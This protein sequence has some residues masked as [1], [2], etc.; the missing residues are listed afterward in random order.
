M[1]VLSYRGH[2]AI[3][4]AAFVAEMEAHAAADRI[5]AGHYWDGYTGCAIGCGLSSI[6]GLQGGRALDPFDP[7]YSRHH[8]HATA[9]GIPLWLSA[10][11]DTLFENLPKLR[12]QLFP[13]QFARALPDGA[14][15]SGL[16]ER[17]AD[18]AQESGW[19]SPI[20][21][22]PGGALHKPATAVKIADRLLELMA[23]CPVVAS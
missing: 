1:S 10:L 23:A 19:L 15:L 8:A 17:V 5:V 14:D 4:K 16:L 2:P 22:F 9:L 6:L 12:R 20:I 7:Y 13:V 3:T 21:D 18:A 11:Q